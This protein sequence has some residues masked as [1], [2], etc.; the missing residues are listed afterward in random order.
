MSLEK[1]IFDY[2]GGLLL[3]YFGLSFMLSKLFHTNF[4]INFILLGGG[5]CIYYFI[6]FLLK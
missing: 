4:F 3:M 5:G 6:K 2:N 1:I